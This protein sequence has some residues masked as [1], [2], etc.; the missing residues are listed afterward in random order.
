MSCDRVDHRKTVLKC[1]VIQR[2]I[3]GP[4]THV[5]ALTTAVDNLPNH[6]VILN[7][8]DKFKAIQYNLYIQLV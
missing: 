8:I 5:H 1:H 4:I 3:R 7:P 2:T 6:P